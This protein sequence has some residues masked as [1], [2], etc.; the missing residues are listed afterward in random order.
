M[1]K[2]LHPIEWEWPW[3]VWAFLQPPAKT[4]DLECIVVRCWR[5]WIYDGMCM[6]HNHRFYRDGEYDDA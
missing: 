4:L 5:P 2:L 1:S 3:L 6:Y